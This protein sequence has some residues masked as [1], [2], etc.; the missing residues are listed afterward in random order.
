MTRPLAT[1]HT[2]ETDIVTGFLRALERCDIDAA[3]AMVTED[4]VYQNVS[5]PTIRGR[6]GLD[7]A[8]RPML[9]PGRMGFAVC[10]HHVACDGD[11][12]LT[13]RTD[14]ISVGRFRARFWVYGRFVVRDG[15]IAVWRDSFD[16]FDITVGMVRGLAGVLVPVANRQ[17]PS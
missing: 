17:M 12:V 9:R 7:R 14:E 16:W 11:V 6:R 5:L 15:Q 10:V 4:L 3:L 8:F 2:T 13:D 1:V